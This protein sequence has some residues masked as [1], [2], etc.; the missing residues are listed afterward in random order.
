VRGIG[1]LPMTAASSALGFIAFM[2]AGFGF[3]FAAFLAGAFVAAFFA[4]AF[5]AAAF[6]AGAF[7]AAA[8]FAGAFFAAFFAGAAFFAV[9]FAAAFLL[10]D[11]FMAAMEVSQKEVSLESAEGAHASPVRNKM[12]SF[13]L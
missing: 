6:F 7:F 12:L 9:F 2:N 8:F 11:F 5:F 10:P 13:P 3:R 1:L 4:G